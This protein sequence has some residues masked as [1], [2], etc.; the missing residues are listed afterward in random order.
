MRT[1]IDAAGEGAKTRHPRRTFRKV[2]LFVVTPATLIGLAI[3]YVRLVD[4]VERD[5]AFCALCHQTRKEYSLWSESAHRK[6]IC[7]DCHHEDRR[8]ALS[9][10]KQFVLE[11][12]PA[13]K[14]RGAKKKRGHRPKV[15]IDQCA[16]C[17]MQH[18]SKWV[19]V[20]GSVGHRVH[21]AQKKIDCLRCH[22]R[23]IHRF[24]DALKSCAD[25]HKEHVRKA[26]GM[27]KL[28]CL[29]CHNFLDRKKTLTPSRKTCIECHRSR[30]VKKTAFPKHAAMAQFLCSSCHKPHQ[31][32]EKTLASCVECH[33]SMKSYG[34]HKNDE[35]QKCVS[36]HR[37][38]DWAVEGKY[39]V[40]CHDDLKK[41]HHEGKSCWSCHSFKRGVSK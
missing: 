28:H 5:P 40:G 26:S 30:G 19:H 20:E 23:G 22:A 12:R 10:L 17:H 32:K 39:C 16:K 3:G 4:Y 41:G 35:H 34:E 37:A 11:G 29:A 21:L 36:C 27:E 33:D 13:D 24:S 15:V 1:V 25:C 7:Q 14:K 31:P 38:H 6:I 9:V 2:L 8:E 18:D